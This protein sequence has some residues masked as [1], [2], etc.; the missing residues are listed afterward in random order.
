MDRRTL[1]AAAALA[2]VAAASRA[3]YTTLAPTAY[4]ILQVADLVGAEAWQ[5]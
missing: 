4:T 5:W 2:A 3:L 1:L